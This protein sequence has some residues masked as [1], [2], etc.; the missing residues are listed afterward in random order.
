M[1]PDV[2]DE[3]M[4]KN[5]ERKES[6][7]YSFFVFFTKFASGL[8]V[9]F[10]SNFLEFSGY[11]DCPNGCCTQPESIK[12]ALRMLL[13]PIPIVMILIAMICL[14]LHPIDEKKRKQNKEFL[15]NLRYVY[16]KYRVIF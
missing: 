14:Y 12:L 8:S 4:V 7:F 5:G 6:I 11:H 9:A 16:L 13:V 3:F 15:E 2:I 1:L 10:S